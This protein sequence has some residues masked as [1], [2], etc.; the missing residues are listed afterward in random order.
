METDCVLPRVE[1][2]YI[3]T[4]QMKFFLHLVRAN[5]SLVFLCLQ[6]NTQIV[7]KFK[8]AAEYFSV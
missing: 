8:I 3:F 7:P 2:I 6:E 4:I 1:N 5:I